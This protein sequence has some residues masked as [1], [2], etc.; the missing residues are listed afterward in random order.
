LTHVNV[1]VLGNIICD[2]PD[3]DVN[4]AGLL[5]ECGGVILNTV[6]E[7]IAASAIL[8]FLMFVLLYHG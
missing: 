6:A 5:S 8:T 2:I 7:M 3:I 1:D 4:Q